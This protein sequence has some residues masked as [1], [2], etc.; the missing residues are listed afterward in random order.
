MIMRMIRIIDIKNCNEVVLELPYKEWKSILT[1][2]RR[3]DAKRAIDGEDVRLG[4]VD[5]LMFLQYFR[6]KADLMKM[7]EV[8]MMLYWTAGDNEYHTFNIVIDEVKR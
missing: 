1:T 5:L 6:D 2:L 3:E 4:N 7:Y 8:A